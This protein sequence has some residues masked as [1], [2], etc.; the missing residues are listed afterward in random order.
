[1]KKIFLIITVLAIFCSCSTSSDENGNSTTIAVPLPAS[2][3]AVTTVFSNQV[4]LIWTDNSTNES[5]F[6]IERKT[7]TGSFTTV[8]TVNT[9]VITYS[10]NGLN[11]NTEYVYRV[12][13]YNAGGN[14]PSYSNEVTILTTP[15]LNIISAAIGTQVWQKNNLDV[16][17][18]RDGTSIPQVTNPTEWSNLT[19][20]A[21]CYYENNS[22]NVTEYGR[23]YNW[24]A[25]AGIYDSASLSNPSL[26]KQ[27]APTGWHIPSNA[28]YTTLF[29]YLG[30]TSVAGGKMKESGNTYWYV[31]FNNA[32][33]SSG[34]SA[35]GAGNR[36]PGG[37]GGG[38]GFQSKGGACWLWTSQSQNSKFL[39][40][41]L[42]VVNMPLSLNTGATVRCI[43]D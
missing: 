4:N 1:M 32:T 8:G 27:L 6:K 7:G 41:T 20:G 16:I 37:T 19:T 12:Y 21:W 3:L 30:G 36:Y 43:K 9:N 42:E 33:N 31:N 13:S 38:G 17:T 26:R 14:S 11:Q 24:Y 35:R 15:Q 25:V 39:D 2:N 34:F 22:A 10:D 40:S 28:E 18:Y 23:L 29:N 5:G